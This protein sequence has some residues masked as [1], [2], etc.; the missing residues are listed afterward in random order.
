[1]SASSNRNN[2]AS[3]SDVLSGSTS[4]CLPKQALAARRQR[5]SSMNSV[6]SNFSSN[7]RSMSIIS[8]ELRRNSIISVDDSL[9]RPTRNNSTAS[10]SSL[11]PVTSPNDPVKDNFTLPT[12]VGKSRA[13][14][15]SAV[16][17][18][19]DSESEIFISRFRWRRRSSEKNPPNFLSNLK[20]DFKFK[21]DRVS[22]PP[23]PSSKLLDD[24][25]PSPLSLN[26]DLPLPQLSMHLP[27][28]NIHNSS[29]SPHTLHVSLSA[30][31]IPSTAFPQ[32]SSSPLTASHSL[33]T[34]IEA[35][36][37][38]L[39]QGKKVRTSS[40]SQSIFLKRRLLLSKDIQLEL[41]ANHGSPMVSPTSLN[42]DTRFPTG[43]GSNAH[44]HNPPHGN[45]TTSST[46][47]SMS[48]SPNVEETPELVSSPPHVPASDHSVRS[49][50]KL[51]YELNRKW[52]KAVFDSCS[53]ERRNPL[54]LGAGSTRKRSR[55]ALTSST[56]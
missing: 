24:P 15:S 45:T 50:N 38:P 17:S 16:L 14:T 54:V 20:R 33:L 37:P 7:Q 8:L 6:G 18:D 26:S 4:P 56:D 13:K 34:E 28:T 22:E 47:A 52:N 32:P 1:M 31:N 2:P 9:L 29:S 10:L 42:S 48:A 3:P 5:S 41:I 11:A 30:P 55:S 51:I 19:E 23:K 49:Q 39:T 43:S 12:R 21:Y 25:A 44:L 40:I 46:V 53:P 35:D 27:S 36:I